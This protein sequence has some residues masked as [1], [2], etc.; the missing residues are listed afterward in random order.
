MHEKQNKKIYT[1]G[2]EIFNA[3]SHGT[4]SLL[5]IA[6]TVILIVFPLSI[7]MSGQLSAVAS[8]ALL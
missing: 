3:V 8:M 1:L 5:S 7:T 2:E 4:G 6:G